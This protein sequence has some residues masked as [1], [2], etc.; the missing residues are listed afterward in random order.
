MGL[1]DDLFSKTLSRMS[2]SGVSRKTL[3]DYFEDMK[4][5][6]NDIEYLC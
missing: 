1:F 2:G 3:S 5:H 6:Q 4:K